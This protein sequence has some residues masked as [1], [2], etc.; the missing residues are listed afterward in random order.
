MSRLDREYIPEDSYNRPKAVDRQV[1]LRSADKLLN[2]GIFTRVVSIEVILIELI[3]DDH[4]RI[5]QSA[6]ADICDF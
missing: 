2:D 5:S 3:S 4:P 1:V 6:C